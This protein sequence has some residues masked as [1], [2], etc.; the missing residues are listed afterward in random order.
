MAYLAVFATSQ[1]QAAQDALAATEAATARRNADRDAMLADVAERLE[2]L[3]QTADP[4]EQLESTSSIEQQILEGV[5]VDLEMSADTWLS[6]EVSQGNLEQILREIDDAIEETLAQPDDDQRNERLA[7][8]KSQRS[9]VEQQ[10]TRVSAT[11][12]VRRS[13]IA[14]D[15]RLATATPLPV[16]FATDEGE[17]VQLE[18]EYAAEAEDHQVSV[19]IS[20]YTH[21]K[22]GMAT[23]E[24]A[25][26]ADAVAAALRSS[27]RAARDTAAV[28]PR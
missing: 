16:A 17:V 20:D 4:T 2:R 8:L 12:E 25:T 6:R 15:P 18:L 5:Q 7:L 1:V 11:L 23:E 24:G 28:S 21:T 9:T 3:G 13:R 22:A 10:L 14:D 27:S 19:T 26:L